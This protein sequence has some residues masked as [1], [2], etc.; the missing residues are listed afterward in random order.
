MKKMSFVESF[1]VTSTSLFTESFNALSN[2]KSNFGHAFGRHSKI[3]IVRVF[4]ESR[5]A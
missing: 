1:V 3:P 4:H 5:K 2:V